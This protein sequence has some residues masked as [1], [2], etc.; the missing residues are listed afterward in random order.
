VP[1][2]ELV[3]ADGPFVMNTREEL[4]QAFEGAQALS[5]LATQS[6][7]MR[8]YRHARGDLDRA[9][10][11]TQAHELAG[12]AQHLLGHRARLRLDQGDWVGAE[13]DAHAALAERVHSSG[14]LADAL[15]PLGLLQARRGDPDAMATLQEA[16]EAAFATGELQWT[17]QVAVAR[18]EHAWLHGEERRVAE[19][20]ARVFEE[21]VMAAHPWFGGSCL[22]VAAGG[23]PTAVPG[24]G[25]RTVPA[26]AGRRV[27]GRRRYLAGDLG[28]GI[29]ADGRL[30][31]HGTP[32]TA[33]RGRD[34][35]RPPPRQ[36]AEGPAAV[37][38]RDAM[39][40]QAGGAE[41]RAGWG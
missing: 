20:A 30:R 4:L 23:H 26:A 21:A 13:Q 25:G 24:G 12:Y 22:L 29:T 19:E 28:R 11:F 8:D 27:A 16:T 2:R 40:S 32:P 35:S 14:R 34:R 9:L 38:G 33:R 39:R 7:E 10:A 6:V 41:A 37:C 17:G 31:R 5:N 18:A 1:I 15:V 3:A 36:R